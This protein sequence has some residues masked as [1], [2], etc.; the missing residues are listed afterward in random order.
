MPQSARISSINL[1]SFLAHPRRIESG[2]DGVERGCSAQLGGRIGACRLTLMVLGLV[3]LL[4]ALLPQM[5]AQTTTYIEGTSKGPNSSAMCNSVSLADSFLL[6]SAAGTASTRSITASSSSFYGIGYFTNTGVPGL[7]SWIDGTYVL[8]LDNTTTNSNIKVT[9]VCIMRVSSSGSALTTVCHVGGINTVLS[10]AA[11][12]TFNCAVTSP[13]AT[14]NT[15]RLLGVMVL[16]NTAASRQSVT[17]RSNLSTDK[18]TFTA[19]SPS[20][21]SLSPTAGAVGTSVTISGTAFGIA[22]GTVN[23]NGT[24]ATVSSWSDTSI[25][26]QVPTGATTGSVVV[27]A[28]GVASN[29]VT[30]TVVPPPVVSSVT[31]LSGSAGTAIAISG[32]NFGTTTGTVTFNGTSAPVIA[33]SSTSISANVPALATSGGLV[34]TSSLGIASNSTSFTIPT[35]NISNISPS[36]ARAGASVTIGGSNFGSVAG[37]VTFNGIAGSPTSWSN[38]QI[39][40]PVPATATT[41]PVIV[42]QG[43]ASN[44]VNLTVIPPPSISSLTPATGPVNTAVTIAGSGFGIPQGTSVVKFNGTTATPTSW[45]DSSIVVPVPAGATTGPVTIVAGGTTSNG[46][47]FTVSPGP[48]ITSLLPASGAAGTAVTI[49]GQNFGA[50]QGS[51]VVRFN[52]A[53]A[54]VTSWTNT[55]IGV[56]VPNAATTG[57]VTITVNGQA[58]NGSAFTIIT[59][60]TLSGSVTNSS[61]GA[62]ISGATV[63]AIQAGVVKS[64]ATTL[65]DGSYSIANLTA[66][67]YDVQVSAS[68]FGTALKNSVTVSAGQTAPANF[69]LSSPGSVTGKITQPDGVTGI[70]G[71]NVQVFVGSA[72]GSSATADAGGNY[73]ITGL[74]AGSYSLE[75]SAAS[76]VTSSQ[77]VSVSGGSATT[78]NAILQPLAA[79]PIKYVYDE[80]G[81]LLAAIDPSGDTATYKYDAMGNILSISR[82][83]SSQVSIISFTPQKGVVGSTVTINGTG[84]GATSSQNSVSFNGVSATIVSATTTQIVATVPATATTGSITVTAPGGS[85][86]T[87]AAFTVLADSGAPTISS[88]TPSS[89]LTGSAV[90]ITGTNYDPS[91]GNNRVHFDLSGAV[92]NSATST[93][94]GVT[95]PNTVGSGRISVTTVGGKA[96]SANDFFIPFNGHAVADLGFTGRMNIGDTL[97]VSLPTASK[98]GMVV[99][100]AVGGQRASVQMTSGTFT[101]CTLYLFDPFGKQLASSGCTGATNFMDGQSLPITGTYTLGIDPGGTTGSINLTLLNATDVTGTI[102]FGTPT[103]VA[104]TVPGQNARYTFSG[105][106]AQQVSVSLT[107]STYTGCAGVNVSILKPDGTT[108]SSTGLCGG[109]GFIDSIS[110]PV[111]GTYTLVIDPSGTSTGSITVLIN[112]FSDLSGTTSIGTP[113]TVTTTTAGQNARYTFSGTVGQQISVTLTNSTYTGCAGVNVSILKPD[114][115]TLGSTGLCGGSGFIDSMTLPVTGTYTLVINPSGTSTGSITAL[116]NTFSDISGT[117]SIG[118]PLT[119]TTT[120]AGQNARYT[121]S[122]TAAQQVSVSLTNSTYTGCAG[123]NVSILK[124]DGTTLSSTGLCGG[125]GFIDSVSLPMTGTYTLVIDP[126]GT[127]TGSIT[128][129]IN[130]FSDLSGTTSIGTPLTVTTTTAGQN[131][132]YTFSG[133]VG[134]QISVTLTNSTYTGCAGVNVS[135]LKPDGTTLG[136]TGLCGGSGFID[137]MTLPV[138]GTYTL[139]IN[140]SGTSTGSITALINTFSDISGTTSIG[141]PLTVTTTT[142]GQNARYTFSGTVG[143]QISVSLTNSTYT[144]CAGVNVSILKPDGT[145]L[146]STGLCGGSGFIDSVSLPV[147]GTYTLVIDPSGTST[148]SIMVLINTFSDISGTTSIGT[149]LTVTTTTAGQNARYTFSGTVGQQISVTLT[150]STYAGCAGVN[151]SILKPDGT[152]LSSTGLCGGSGFID[153]VSLPVTG[154]YTLVIDPSGTS[155][156]SIT[157]LINTFSDISGTTSIGTPL[158]VT[159]TTAGQNARYTF[160][161]TVGQ[162]ISV[163]LTNSTYAG[164]A[165]VNVSILKPDGTTLSSTGLCGASGTV[166]PSSLPTTG[167]YTVLVNPAGAATG[168]VT[169]T[170]TLN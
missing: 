113:L 117:T 138:T 83:N 42:T 145:T 155:T 51:S 1:L 104:T 127:S 148:G 10:T 3:F 169:A 102:A 57:Q 16:Q 123:V 12:R 50:S 131:A 46:V 58:S 106:A 125:S 6:T 137:S 68:G 17:L 53:A 69:S 100:D 34:V 92:V 135:I 79:N 119:V 110:L 18:I 40:V 41:G 136:S 56:T 95:V 11:V 13:T 96:T 103:T 87:S 129:L 161:G 130:T 114:G 14:A 65:A 101:T 166:G 70:A 85:V 165:G 115:T 151:V 124:P 94:L 132:R 170:L 84:F 107:N 25:V 128:V 77:S 97:N 9:D 167:T 120:T 156:G 52:G 29:G 146:S 22:T 64:S 30:F 5:E 160:S 149:P 93:T 122:G 86:S 60:G 55:S 147:T 139:V 36:A 76:Y 21:S 27:T 28:N 74:N 24:A 168:S 81:R 43:G 105:T 62:A 140:P 61:G 38:T 59:G 112:T 32:S 89:G 88:F 99:F 109:S 159:T 15:D 31:P 33:W 67:G 72:A 150:N 90:T 111:T 144:G 152:T 108:L 48:S 7:T 164:C 35:P 23:F 98:I 82:A 141:T 80:L 54:A 4:G 143:Q 153:S 2:Y 19:T 45:S 47:T 142:A 133:T 158:T 8:T 66:G 118:T 162:Q 39:V 37:T 49:S 71:A 26:V 126:S 116:I 78:A 73:S 44:S 75:A 157:V 163:T 91:P 63:Q 121:F 134:Q 20:I 154:T